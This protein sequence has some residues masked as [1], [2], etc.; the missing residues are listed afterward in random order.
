ML[1]NVG[2]QISPSQ[3][4]LLNYCFEI[5]EHYFPNDTYAYILIDS[6]ART[7]NK[8]MLVRSKIFPDSDGKIRPL[9]FF[10]NPEYKK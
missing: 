7:A 8:N 1:R 9:C 10:V 3:P 5:L 4:N 2:C 6:H